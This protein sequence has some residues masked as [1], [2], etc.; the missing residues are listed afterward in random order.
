[1]IYFIQSGNNGPIKIGYTDKEVKSRLSSM[2]TGNPLQIIVLGTI[3][4]FQ[5]EEKDLHEIFK[6]YKMDRE[7]FYPHPYFIQCVDS[8]I[9]KKTK[10]KKLINRLNLTDKENLYIFKN[11][12]LV[13]KQKIAGWEQD[14]VD[15]AIVS[16]KSINRI[17]KI[18]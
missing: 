17:G 10:L 2:Q 11:G 16:L 7:W 5:D 14:M 1:M 3:Y 9:N 15:K 12:T 4:G 13:G 6:N 8:I 18:F